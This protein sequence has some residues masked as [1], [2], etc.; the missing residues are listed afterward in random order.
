LWE[1]EAVAK[2]AKLFLVTALIY[3]G[4]GLVLYAIAMFD[5]W[6]GFNP[7]AYTSVGST[8]QMLLVGWLTQSAMGL[9]YDRL[10]KS[11]RLVAIVWAC[12]NVGLVLTIV[13]QPALALTGN[14]LVG[15]LVAM[16]GLMQATG[17]VTFAIE[18]VRA[19][20]VRK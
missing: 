11:P 7:L 16:G 10:V 19:L 18:I 6:L 14:D 12:L 2:T 8:M 17:G 4:L 15:G 20:R 13:G 5:V 9:L 3:L 1:E